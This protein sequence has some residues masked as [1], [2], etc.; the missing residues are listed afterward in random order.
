MEG[1]K[2]LKS[3]WR[4]S[5]LDIIIVMMLVLVVVGVVWVKSRA[6]LAARDS[7]AQVK[8]KVVLYQEEVPS[9]TVM[10]VS[11]GDRV[12]E[13]LQRTDFGRVDSVQVKDSIT[14]GTD[15]NG[16]FVKGTRK[17]YSSVMIESSAMGMYGNHGVKIGYGEYYV[18]QTFTML[19]GNASISLRIRDIM[20]Q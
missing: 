17:G 18:G 6:A 10:A 1:N 11:N 13:Q 3:G 19:V 2:T 20:V 4:F 15:E 7:T 5:L 14:W 16:Q 12:I 8:L 9:E